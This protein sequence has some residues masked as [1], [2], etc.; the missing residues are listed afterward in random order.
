MESILY[1]YILWSVTIGIHTST[2]MPSYIVFSLI[3][4]TRTY[5]YTSIRMPRI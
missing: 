1:E 2:R 5:L 4:D 3:R